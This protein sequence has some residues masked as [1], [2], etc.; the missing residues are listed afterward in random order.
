MYDHEY[1]KNKII[2]EMINNIQEHKYTIDLYSF[3]Y[4]FHK[5]PY[6]DYRIYK[7]VIKFYDWD[8]VFKS[9]YIEDC[10]VDVARKDTCTEYQIVNKSTH[11]FMIVTV[12]IV[13]LKRR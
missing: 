13:T 6:T 3:A 2:D 4:G 8:D 10:D 1:M 12:D 11:D 9:F 5:P 7:D